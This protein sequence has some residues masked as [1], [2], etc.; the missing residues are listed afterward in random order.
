MK[1]NYL[2][3]L[4]L[5]LLLFVVRANGQN[6]V[7]AQYGWNLGLVKEK[8]WESEGYKYFIMEINSNATFELRVCTMFKG[9]T[10]VF[11][12]PLAAGS[13][14]AKGDTLLLSD[15]LRIKSGAFKHVLVEKKLR[16]VQEKEGG[17][18]ISSDSLLAGNH[19]Y[20]TIFFYKEGQKWKQ[21]GRDPDGKKQGWWAIY[22]SDGTPVKW[23]LYD[24][25]VIMKEQ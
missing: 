11:S 12:D 16:F 5:P 15:T 7:T 17:R 10:L 13:V 22:A 9:S 8:D 4:V 3:C 2:K 18:L 21:G 14:L 20:Q 19:F 25:G 6:P 24:H 1:P 23:T